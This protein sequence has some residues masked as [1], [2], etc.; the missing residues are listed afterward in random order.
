MVVV[1]TVFFPWK[2]K[3][4]QHLSGVG[5]CKWGSVK[6]NFSVAFT[7]ITA[8]TILLLAIIVLFLAAKKSKS[9]KNC[10]FHAASLV[11]AGKNLT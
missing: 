4:F 8:Q 2:A 5:P 6:K 9:L 1:V 10:D 3:Y 7:D 11:G